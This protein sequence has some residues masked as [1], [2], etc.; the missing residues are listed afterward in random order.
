MKRVGD[1]IKGLDERLA[2]IEEDLRALE[3]GLPNVPHESVP[4]GADETANRVE[5][6]WGEKP[7][8]DFAPKPHWDI[9]EALGILDFERAAKISGARFTL[10]FGAGARLNAR[11]SISFSI[12]TPSAATRGR[13]A[14]HRQRRFAARHRS[15][16]EVRRG[17]VQA[18]R[19]RLLPHPDRRSAGHEHPSR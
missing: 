7:K 16:A 4:V 9:G 13:A 2:A 10:I 11:S 6:T 15:A 19:S 18:H 5:R 12:R 17:S 1:E 14:V 8:F 3:L